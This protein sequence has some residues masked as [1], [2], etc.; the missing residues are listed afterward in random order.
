[1]MIR[2]LVIA[3]GVIWIPNYFYVLQLKIYVSKTCD[4]SRTTQINGHE[5]NKIFGLI[6]YLYIC[7]E[8]IA[9]KVIHFRDE[10]ISGFHIKQKCL[11]L[12]LIN[13]NLFLIIPTYKNF[14]FSF[15]LIFIFFLK[16]WLIFHV[17]AHLILLSK[18]E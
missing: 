10:K 15:F 13:N 11:N 14:N 12:F 18:Q 16:W 2:Q 6:L 1:M 7:E 8:D 9:S 17:L 5:F 4:R 3:K